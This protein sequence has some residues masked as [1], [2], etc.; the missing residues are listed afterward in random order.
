MNLSYL[1]IQSLCILF[2]CAIVVQKLLKNTY[3]GHTVALHDTFFPTHRPAAVETHQCIKCVLK[4]SHI[5]ATFAKN[6]SA[7]RF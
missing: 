4:F 7:Q 1:F 5:W 2:I 3:F 6:H